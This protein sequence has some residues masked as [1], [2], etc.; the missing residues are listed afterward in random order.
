[1]TGAIP[2][3]SRFIDIFF[4]WPGLKEIGP[5]GWTAGLNF[6]NLCHRVGLLPDDAMTECACGYSGNP[7]QQRPKE[8]SFEEASERGRGPRGK[9]WGDEVH[10]AEY[11]C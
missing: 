9:E 8:E 4:S 11:N 6:G 7:E 2:R 3:G 1:M 10:Q 5:P